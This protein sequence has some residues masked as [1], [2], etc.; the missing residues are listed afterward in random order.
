LVN[1][2]RSWIDRF[3][4]H[5]NIKAIFFHGLKIADTSPDETFVKGNFSLATIDLFDGCGFY[6]PIG[7]ENVNNL[8]TDESQGI[9]L[10][11][12]R[13]SDREVNFF[14]Y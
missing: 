7:V 12:I 6:F 2:S 4:L 14:H 8:A 9:F 10:T 5:H 13:I 11:I 3:L 1:L